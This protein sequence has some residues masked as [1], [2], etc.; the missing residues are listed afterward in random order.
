MP[1]RPAAQQRRERRGDGDA[2]RGSV[3]RHAARRHVQVHV[4]LREDVERDPQR[5]RAGAKQAPRGLRRFFH[6]VAELAGQRDLALAGHADRFD[7]HDVAAGRRPCE[8]GRDPNLGGAARHFTLH[9]RLSR[10]LLEILRGDS[11]ARR[12]PLDHLECGLAEHAL[13]LALQL[14]DARFSRVLGD[15]AVERG[16]GDMGA[17]GFLA[18]PQSCL[19]ELARHEIAL[20]DLELLGR[21]VADEGELLHAVE[22]RIG[23]RHGA[24]RRRDEHHTG[25]IERHL[26]VVIDKGR[27]LRGIEHLE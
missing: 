24:V 27:V 17:L 23:N 3:F 9:L 4:R 2:R 19:L 14:A 21:R 26:E 22:Q 1:R 11:H 16:V 6:H 12:L 7:E 8:P 10:V 15:Q 13:D 5:A 20:G 25:Q 18:L